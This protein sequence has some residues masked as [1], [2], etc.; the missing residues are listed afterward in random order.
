MPQKIYLDYAAATPLDPQVEKKMAQVQRYFAN[1]SSI[2]ALGRRSRQC[3]DEARNGFA[4]I[5]KCNSNEI[6]FTHSG[7]ES[8][9]LAVLGIAR[10]NKKTGKHIIVSCIEHDSVLAPLLQ[11]KKEGFRISYIPVNSYGSI[12]VR[13]LE[14]VI[15]KDTL[16]VSIIAANNEIGTIQP[17]KKISKV[18]HTKNP[19][20]IFHTDV[21]QLSGTSRIHPSSFGADALTLNSNK[22]YGPKGGALLYIKQNLLLEP[23]VYGGGQEHGYVSGTENTT[24]IVG[25]FHAFEKVQKNKEK[26][27]RRLK[28]IRSIF[29][30]GILALQ[31]NI[32]VNGHPTQFLPHILHVTFQNIDTETLLIALDQKGICVSSGSACQSGSLKHSSVLEAIGLSSAKNNAH[33]RFSFGRG[34]TVSDIHYTLG[35]LAEILS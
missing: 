31:P 28:K 33:I 18:I 22:I 3:I 29:I 12:N 25:F 34:T 5:L 6:I 20:C 11:L 4:K 32:C 13:E 19:N 24:G 8:N 27:S 9:N 1:P 2:H 26:E 30:R 17:L 7:T 10:A 16:L 21:C 35:A 15:T 23:L 14:R